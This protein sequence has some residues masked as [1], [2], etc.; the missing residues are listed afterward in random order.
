[1]HAEC[2]AGRLKLSKEKEEEVKSYVEIF[3]T[4]LDM[5]DIDIMKV[6]NCDPTWP[7]CIFDFTYKHKANHQQAMRSRHKLSNFVVEDY[8]YPDEYP[9]SVSND[10]SNEASDRRQKFVDDEADVLKECQAH[11]CCSHDDN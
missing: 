5:K 10:A 4:N 3:S 9:D 7:I 1:M 8:W 11:I 2:A 6:F